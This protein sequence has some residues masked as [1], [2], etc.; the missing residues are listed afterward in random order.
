[1]AEILRYADTGSAAGG[2]GT[3]PALSGG[4]HAYQSINAAL[5]AEKQDL[6]DGGGDT[7]RLV[8]ARSGG[9]GKDTT[10]FR[11]DA[12]DWTTNAT[13][14]ITIESSDFPSDGIWDDTAYVIHN[15]DSALAMCEITTGHVR[16]NNMQIEVTE[17]AGHRQGLRFDGSANPSDHFVSNCIFKGNCSGGNGANAITANGTN[18]NVTIYNSIAYDFVDG[19]T[20]GYTG[21]VGWSVTIEI[22]NCTVYNCYTGYL[23]NVAGSTI[24]NCAIGNCADD[25]NVGDTI[26]YCCSDDGDGTN[27][28]GPLS[29]S[30]ANEFVDAG[31]GDFT[32]VSGGNILVA[33]QDDPGSGLFS[34]DITGAAYSTG[35]WARGA[36]AGPASV[37]APKLHHYK[38]AAG[39]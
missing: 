5:A 25:F 24:K 21:F 19:A 36:F 13:S 32:P 38:H 14:Y 12:G 2:D 35:S 39:L 10:T 37:V 23:E 8:C 7:F 29:G 28:N 9:G 30:W 16:F 27:A 18:L 3:T 34:T 26:D 6:T 20:A 4:N 22:Y 31:N 15:N 11:I 1:M 33:G 17:S